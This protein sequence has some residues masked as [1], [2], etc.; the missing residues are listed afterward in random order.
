V[1]LLKRDDHISQEKL[2]ESVAVIE[3]SGE[4]LLKLVNDLLDLA[5]IEAGKLELTPARIDLCELLDHVA[6]L[7]RVRAVNAG[8]TLDVSID[9]AAFTPVVTDER[10]VRQILLNLL[11]NAVKFT[12]RGGRVALYAQAERIDRQRLRVRFVVEDSGIGIEPAQLARIFEPFHRVTTGTRVVEGTGLGLTITQRLVAALKGELSVKSVPGVGTTFSVTSEFE[13][14]AVPQGVALPVSEIQG[15]GG[16]TRS[17]LVADDDDDNR[18]LVVQL[19]ESVG[20][21]V[22]NVGNGHEALSRI[23]TVRP[24]LILT[25]LVMPTLDGME[26]VR[27]IR[28]NP[29]LHAIP[30]VAMSAS[31]SDYTREEALQAGCSSF[32]P[33]PL[34][35]A[36]LLDSIGQQLQLEW[37]YREPPQARVPNGVADEAQPFRLQPDLAEELQHLAK[38][39]DILALAARVDVALSAEP[40]A[41]AFC[42]EMRELV[43]RYDIRGIRQMLTAS[44]AN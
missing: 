14:A 27:A 13:I 43:S 44:R 6:S 16:P 24:D 7:T 25:D 41:R 8:L 30:V 35:L 17:V 23:R 4:H 32:L 34:K 42:A 29:A 1:Q 19:L 20:F 21:L 2:R 5:R 15:Y 18:R 38:Q 33:K 37:R 3:R 31:A 9:M 40:A 39:G 28:T 11:G 26:L 22:Q 36:D 10:V 12:E